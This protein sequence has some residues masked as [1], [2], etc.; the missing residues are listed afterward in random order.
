MKQLV[1]NHQGHPPFISSTGADL[2][3]QHIEKSLL[4]CFEG[5]NGSRKTSSGHH[6]A[7]IMQCFIHL[8]V[9]QLCFT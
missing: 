7:F 2:F 6:A 3:W 4:M 1:S 8:Y 5:A 9:A